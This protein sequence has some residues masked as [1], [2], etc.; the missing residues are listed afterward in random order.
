[1]TDLGK[2]CM[3]CKHFHLSLGMAGY[4]EYTPGEVGEVVCQIGQQPAMDTDRY[5]QEFRRW[6]RFGN[7]CPKWEAAQDD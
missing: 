3:M 2:S 7:D 4:S 5:E 1:M 6:I